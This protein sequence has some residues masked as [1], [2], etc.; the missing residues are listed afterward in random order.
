MDV[1][2]ALEKSNEIARK[3][4]IQNDILKGQLERRDRMLVEQREMFYQ[5]LL[6]YR[7]QV[8]FPPPDI[9]LKL[10]LFSCYFSC[11]RS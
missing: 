9:Q 7:E 2:L 3:T 8:S 4:Q 5:Q 11:Y 6:R 1:K 10:N